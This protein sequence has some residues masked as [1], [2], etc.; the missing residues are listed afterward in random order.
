MAALGELLQLLGAMFVGALLSEF[1][2]RRRN[3]VRATESQNKP[4]DPPEPS[5]RSDDAD[6]AL[7]DDITD[8]ER[9]SIGELAN[10]LADILGDGADGGGGADLHDGGSSP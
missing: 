5:T 2:F 9:A 6:Q 10:D 3:A 7:Q 1:L 4:I 8:S